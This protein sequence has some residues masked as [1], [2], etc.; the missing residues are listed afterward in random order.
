VQPERSG[1]TAM[2]IT[3]GNADFIAWVKTETLASTS[4]T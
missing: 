1:A 4:S 3:A 2:P